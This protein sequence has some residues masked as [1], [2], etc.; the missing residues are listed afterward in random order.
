[1]A[2]TAPSTAPFVSHNEQVA[3]RHAEHGLFVVPCYNTP[4][5]PSHKVAIGKWGTQGTNDVA[6][7]R[8][9]WAQWPGALPAIATKPSGLAVLD[10]DRH[11]K[12]KDGV[13]AVGSVFAEHGGW[14]PTPMTRT[15]RDGLHI[16]FRD[17]PLAPLSNSSRGLPKGIDVKAGGGT[18]G[19]YVIAPGAML[20]DGK[21][22]QPVEDCPDLCEAFKTN[23]IPPVPGWLREKLRT[24]SEEA[25]DPNTPLPPPPGHCS[26]L[27]KANALIAL[28]MTGTALA[29]T[30]TRRGTEA[31]KQA[32]IMGAWAVDGCITQEAAR[33]AFEEAAKINKHLEDDP[34]DFARSFDRGFKR[35][36]L[37]RIKEGRYNGAPISEDILVVN[38]F[39]KQLHQRIAKRRM[40]RGEQNNATQPPPIETANAQAP[41]QNQPGWQLPFSDPFPPPVGIERV[42]QADELLSTAAP[43]QKWIVPPFIPRRE[44]SSCTGDGG[45]GKSTLA[46][47]LAT[48]CVSGAE[49][50][51]NKVEPSNVLYI[52]AEDDK[53]ELHRRLERINKQLQIPRGKLAGLKLI[54]LSEVDTTAL[55][56]FDNKGQITPTA[57]FHNI[58]RIAAEHKAGLI[59]L[60]AV[61]DFFAGNENERRE[62]RAF[63]GLLRQLARRLDAAVLVIAHPSVDGMKTG[64]GYSGSTH[65]NNAVRSRLTFTKETTEDGKPDLSV[66]VLELAKSNRAPPG[67]KIRMTWTEGRLKELRAGVSGN[68]N[69]DQRDKQV[70]LQLLAR[71]R[72]E[73]TRV[74]HVRGPNYAPAVMA[75]RRDG[76]EIGNGRLKKAMLALL[77]EEAIRNAE[78]GPPSK[79]RQFLVTKEEWEQSYAPG[80]GDRKAG[81]PML[82]KGARRTP[83]RT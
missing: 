31:Y 34:I 22:Y 12:D 81:N 19:G 63:I 54:D 69:A 33:V 2:Q 73:G 68:P 65:W 52:S 32:A 5:G 64:R 35:G 13:T 55:A 6:I 4:G 56:T 38:E 66:M 48:A 78:D 50:I 58:E 67:T 71:L 14:P 30:Q 39:A 18:Y 28:K 57:R 74:S 24:Q 21:V 20:P 40:Q 75:E 47:Q 61:A 79:R 41:P 83:R 42:F 29:Q 37:E 44:V 80:K 9:K 7:I 23:A 77:H 27:G 46:L 1:M 11:H 72:S 53:D 26:D 49:W 70:F 60:D 25:I 3:V 45:G 36:Y 51:G 62:V 15:A 43:E 82:A 59:I 8:R 17:D 10:C 16:F 76:Q